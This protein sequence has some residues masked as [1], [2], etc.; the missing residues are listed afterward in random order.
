MHLNVDLK[1]VLRRSWRVD[2]VILGSALVLTLFYN[3][4]FFNNVLAI[5]PLADGNILFI[6][7]L[8]VFLFAL[9]AF[10]LGLLCNCLTVKPVLMVVFP[11]AAM[12]GY[13]MNHYNIVIDTAMLGN[14]MATDRREVRDLLSWQLVFSF[15]VFGLLPALAISRLRIQ[16]VN[17]GRALVKKLQV[18]LGS[19]ALI[20]L[21]VLTQGSGYAGFFREHKA[22]RYYANPVT[23]LY[24][25]GKFVEEMAPEPEPGLRT[26][27]GEDAHIPA[28][29][30]DRE[31]VILVVGETARADHFSLQGYPRQTNPLLE[32]ANVHFFPNMT[33]C[34]TS[35]ALSVPCM[36]SLATASDFEVDAAGDSE[37]LLDVLHH[38]GVNVLWRDNNSDSKG[39]AVEI[40]EEDF[41]GPD[42]NPVCDIE[43]RDVGMLAGLDEW[44]EATES[45]DVAIVLHQMGNHGPA[46]YKR[47]PK[48]FERFTPVCET[49]ALENCTEAEITNAYDNALLY[50]DYFLAQVIHFLEQYDD[51]FETA[52]FYISDHGESLGEN[53]LYLH[54]LPNF[55]APDVQRQV[56][57][58]M[59][60]GKHYGINAPL[61][62]ERQQVAYSHDNFF[63]TVL[64]FMEIQ[65]S[66][67]DP[68][69]DI[70]GGAH[71]ETSM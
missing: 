61:L 57:A 8:C 59:W 69:L 30:T 43:C 37:N 4:A 66:I 36:F 23:T 14:V 17:P 31:L 29:D 16:R 2:T 5:Y 45:G 12:S 21:L 40:P 20:A 56:P 3:V 68:Q 27:V 9:T 7:S 71:T 54:G 60:F 34:A 49:T 65:T 6:L 58:L 18:T 44:I 19:V 11:L 62:A 24:S 22:L 55:M 50:T 67:Y 33:S 70:I 42:R 35:T 32:N 10:L 47:Y 64:G 46:Y 26:P 63:H 52:M 15:S 39:V 48:A 41:R 25:L 1:R 53:G 38:A 13:F 51:R 28:T